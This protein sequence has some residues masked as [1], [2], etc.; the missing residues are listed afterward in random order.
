VP[1]RQL[2][3]V[4]PLRTTALHMLH[5]HRLKMCQYISRFELVITYMLHKGQPVQLEGHFEPVIATVNKLVEN[6][7]DHHYNHFGHHD[8][9]RRHPL[10]DLM[11]HSSVAVIR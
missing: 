9:D 1:V 11:P 10:H 2:V 7:I 3:V 8:C 5:T 4:Q 6:M